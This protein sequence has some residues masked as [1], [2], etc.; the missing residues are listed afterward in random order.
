M[1]RWSIIVAYQR[2]PNLYEMA[3]DNEIARGPL[4]YAL[5]VESRRLIPDNAPAGASPGA[6]D[7]SGVPTSPVSRQSRATRHLPWLAG[8]L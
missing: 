4:V 2:V 8:Q 6:F 3:R 5:E 7:L 1:C